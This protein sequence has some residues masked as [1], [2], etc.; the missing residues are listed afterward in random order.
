[1]IN[2]GRLS[3]MAFV[4]LLRESAFVIGLGNPVYSPTP[5]EALA[6]GAAWLNPVSWQDT[7]REHI[8][9][10]SSQHQ[11]L[12][13]LGFPYVYNVELSDLKSVLR[14]AEL[15]VTHRFHSFVPFWNRVESVSAQVCAN[16]LESDALCDC[17]N[18]KLTD[19]NV[20]CRGSFYATNSDLVEDNDILFA[21][22]R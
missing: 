6:N 14:A 11:G 17:E 5:L 7:G 3:P 19:E 12:K 22:V 21:P 13:L 10:S 2:H 9:S 4:M 1:M 16:L 15:A 20:E 18:A 8:M